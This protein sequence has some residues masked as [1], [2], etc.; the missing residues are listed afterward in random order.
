[1]S[2]FVLP[3]PFSAYAFEPI[4]GWIMSLPVYAYS[5]IWPMSDVGQ[6]IVFFMTNIWTFLLRKLFVPLFC[7]PVLILCVLQTTA[8]TS[9]TRCTTRASSSILASFRRCGI[10]WVERML[11]P[12]CYSNLS[13][14]SER[15]RE[16]E[17]SWML[18]YRVKGRRGCYMK[19]K[20]SV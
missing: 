5:F 2:S 1:M 4:E 17:H 10:G 20:C 7:R 8:A 15:G 16:L 11:I 6:L 12:R 13:V 18:G 3:T 19:P 14:I 9:S